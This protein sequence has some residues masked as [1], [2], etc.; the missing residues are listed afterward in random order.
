MS[1]I[2]N[3]SDTM[4]VSWAYPILKTMLHQPWARNLDEFIICHDRIFGILSSKIQRMIADI[5]IDK[6]NEMKNERDE[7]L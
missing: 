4:K 3:G 2:R 5:F 1:D 6:M 7:K